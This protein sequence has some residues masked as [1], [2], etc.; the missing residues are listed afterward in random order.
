MA[1]KNHG[2]RA[3]GIGR[4]LWHIR[5]KPEFDL[6]SYLDIIRPNI[7]SVREKSV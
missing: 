7:E 2:I 4:F 3:L 1:V 5:R 6:T